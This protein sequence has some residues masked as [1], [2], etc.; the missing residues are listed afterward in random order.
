MVEQPARTYSLTVRPCTFDPSRFRW[1]VRSVDTAHIAVAGVSFA[2]EEE[3]IRAGNECLRELTR[4]GF[5]GQLP[6]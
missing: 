6:R 4:H 2:T 1:E 5:T 3:A